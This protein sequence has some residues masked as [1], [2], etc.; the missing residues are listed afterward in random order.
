MKMLTCPLCN[1]KVKKFH[2]CSHLIPEWMYTNGYDE[3]YKTLEISRLKQKVTKRQQGIYAQFICRK[4]E[5]ETQIFDHYA[6]LILT[7]KSPDSPE[8]K[9]ISKEK[10]WILTASSD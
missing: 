8:Y 9:C 1:E 5:K 7:D 2:K 6:S 4:C 3:K 10:A